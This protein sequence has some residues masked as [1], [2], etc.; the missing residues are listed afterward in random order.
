MPAT[1]SGQITGERMFRTLP[2]PQISTAARVTSRAIAR[3]VIASQMMRACQGV[4]E[5]RVIGKLQTP[6]PKLQRNPKSQA[7]NIPREVEAALGFGD[8][9]F[10]GAWD[11]GLGA[12]SRKSQF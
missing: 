6:N 5:G 4:G 12:F 7:A 10:P 9:R 3:P 1:A 11:L 8:W 2:S